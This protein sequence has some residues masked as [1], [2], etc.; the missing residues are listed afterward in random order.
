[1][2]RQGRRGPL[3]PDE[4]LPGPV[5]SPYVVWQ[6][7]LQ[8]QWQRQQKQQRQRPGRQLQLQQWQRQQQWRQQLALS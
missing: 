2:G 4:R 8:L 3:Q 6:Q 7:P 5:P 1:M